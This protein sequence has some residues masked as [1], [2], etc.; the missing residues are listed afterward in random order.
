MRK[1]C[2][3]FMRT[4]FL[5]VNNNTYPNQQVFALKKSLL[6]Y[7]KF[8]SGMHYYSNKI[9]IQSLCLKIIKISQGTNK[10]PLSTNTNHYNLTLTFLLLV[11][12]KVG[13]VLTT[14]C[15]RVVKNTDHWVVSMLDIRVF[16]CIVRCGL[17]LVFAYH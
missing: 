1:R 6:P 9:Q 14:P 17:V 2:A 5:T 3:V 10:H 8:V 16:V 12:I 11:I 7:C 15:C 4:N 13:E